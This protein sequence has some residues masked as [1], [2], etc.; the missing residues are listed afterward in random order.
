VT[1]QYFHSAIVAGTVVITFLI[2][3]IVTCS[4]RRLSDGTALRIFFS[5]S[6]IEQ[7]LG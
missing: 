5:F 1:L 4:I 7:H 6:I 2:A 3:I